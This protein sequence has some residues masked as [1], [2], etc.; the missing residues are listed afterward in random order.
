[1]P[2]TR[3]EDGGILTPDPEVERERIEALEAW[4]A[5]RDEAAVEGAL[6]KL[7][8]AARDESANIMPATIASLKVLAWA[9]A[10]VTSR[11]TPRYGISMPTSPRATLPNCKPPAGSTL[12]MSKSSPSTASRS[13][14]AERTASQSPA[15]AGVLPRR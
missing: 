14:M 12:G 11:I 1:M 9:L 6:A 15:P 3:D 4:K 2:L 8:E 13:P 10:P 7:A 5:E